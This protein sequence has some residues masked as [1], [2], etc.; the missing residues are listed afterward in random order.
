MTYYVPH[1]VLVLLSDPLHPTTAFYR[2][3]G[4]KYMT[5]PISPVQQMVELGF[6]PRLIP[7]PVV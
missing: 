3:G 2:W 4:S 6:E 5:C 7:E 1:S